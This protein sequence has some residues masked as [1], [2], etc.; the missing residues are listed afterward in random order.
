MNESVRVIVTCF[1]HKSGTWIYIV[2]HGLKPKRDVLT[3]EAIGATCN[4]SRNNRSVAV[5][6]REV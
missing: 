2:V 5:Y 6:E 3:K 1:E 4:V